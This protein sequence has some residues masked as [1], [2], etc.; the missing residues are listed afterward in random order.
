MAD[1]GD[2]YVFQLVGT[3]KNVK[4]G[5]KPA[6]LEFH[7]HQEDE[8]LCP[9]S[10]IKRYIALTEPWRTLGVPSAFF[11]SFRKPHKPVCKATLARWIKE[12][13]NLADIDTK[14]FQAHSLRGAST[15]KALLK[16]LSVKEI[17]DHG[18]W[19]LESTWQK[20]YHKK[21]EY[22]AKKFQDSILKL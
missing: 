15:S 7:V 22:S 20:F 16:G 4:N 8:K 11:L 17:I 12:T 5:K 18:K 19:S 6:P 10:C 9:I 13:L 1:Y 14:V 2:R 21:V 3:V